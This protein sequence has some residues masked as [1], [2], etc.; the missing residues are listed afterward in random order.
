MLPITVILGVVITRFS[1]KN[2]LNLKSI[3]RVDAGLAA[4]GA[5]QHF[6]GIIAAGADGKPLAVGFADHVVHQQARR[7]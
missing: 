1:Q 5:G 2:R 6:F 7:L 4:A 3:K